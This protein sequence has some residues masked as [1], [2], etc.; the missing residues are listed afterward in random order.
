MRVIVAGSRTILDFD[1]VAGA[2]RDSKFPIRQVVSGGA[3]GVDRLGELWATR[4]ELPEGFTI[5]HAD[6][7][8]YGRAAGAIRNQEMADY[9]DAL[10]LVWDGKSRGSADMLRRAKA[11]GIPI[12]ERIVR[13]YVAILV[14]PELSGG[15]SVQG[16][17]DCTDLIHRTYG[18]K[19]IGDEFTAT[20][21]L[22]SLIMSD[23]CTP[24]WVKIFPEG[25]VIIRK[26]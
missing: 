21:H 13:S 25:S 18:A 3:R 5:F 9:A 2:I 4:A 11:K 19:D 8:K 15:T 6:W 23:H 1:I 22:R 14:T 10:I 24:E 16:E 7:N 12:F 20:D 17:W 26:K